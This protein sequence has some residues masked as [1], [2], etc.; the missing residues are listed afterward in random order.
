MSCLSSLMTITFH[1][2]TVAGRRHHLTGATDV[3]EKVSTLLVVL[4]EDFDDV[5]EFKGNDNQ[6]DDRNSVVAFAGQEN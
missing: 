3:E 4:D 1:L 6:K 2:A 5:I